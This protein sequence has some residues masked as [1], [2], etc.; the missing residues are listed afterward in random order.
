[1][2]SEITIDAPLGAELE[3][4]GLEFYAEFWGGLVRRHPE[5]LEALS[6]LA[7]VY[8]M[9][10]RHEEGLAIDER[11][12]RALPDSHL[13]RYNLACSLA[14]VGRSLEALDALERAVA[15][16]YDD[17]DHMLIDED[18]MGLHSEVRFQRLV[19]RLSPS[20]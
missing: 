6:E 11:L 19:K 16:G 14:L 15:L 1:M 7:Q 20:D 2:I 3:Q 12:V 10:G 9:L 13:V 5:N 8:T 18:L 17:L 4:L